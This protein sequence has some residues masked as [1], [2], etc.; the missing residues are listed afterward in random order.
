M[1]PEPCDLTIV[2]VGME[3]HYGYI[4]RQL[5]LIDSLNP[6]QAYRMIAVDNA[7]IGA[8]DLAID[9]PRCEVLPGI[10]PSSL[11]EEGRGSYHHAA[12]LNIAIRHVRTRFAL[13]LDPDLFVVYWRWVSECL[14]HIR[15]NN[16]AFFGAPWHSRWYR[17]WR[18]F[19]CV[20]FLLIDLQQAPANEIDFTPALVEDRAKD[21]SKVSTWLRVHA[22]LLYSRLLIE[23]RRDTG[24]R[25]NQAFRGRCKVDLLEPV[26]D[27][28]AELRAPTHLTT[29]EGRRGERRL[30]RRW[31]FLPADGSYVSPCDAPGFDSGAFESL[32]PERFVW[33]GAPFAFHMRRNV[34]DFVLG[35]A[36]QEPEEE[37]L[38]AV[39]AE[40][41]EGGV[42][43]EWR[44]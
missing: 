8:P 30:P 36:D 13:I 42:W 26:V 29:R 38:D 4:R 23:S 17:K 24:W 2:T 6:G 27:L 33:R 34:R 5:Q 28:A 37:S 19:P 15:A 40:A 7:T 1:S 10:D 39:L 21:A 12:A 31:S 14:E 18:G 22:P 44:H 43:T 3:K 16:L 41:A 11:P 20:H 32:G 35:H 9:D 25:L